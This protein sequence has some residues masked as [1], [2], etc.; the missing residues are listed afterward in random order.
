LA[1][2]RLKNIRPI[3]AADFSSKRRE[4]A[5]KMGPIVV[6]PSEEDPY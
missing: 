4:L 2:L 6:D 1:A 3:V 5:V